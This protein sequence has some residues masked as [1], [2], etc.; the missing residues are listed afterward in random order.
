MDS[1]PSLGVYGFSGCGGCQAVLLDGD[2]LPLELAGRFEIR[3]YAPLGR[4]AAD[5]RVDVALVEGSVST[6]ADV[7]R[8][9]RIRSASAYL[10]ALGACAASGG[11]QSLRALARDGGRWAADVLPHPEWLDLLDTPV[12]LARHVRVD[13][14][15]Y[16]CPI[17][18]RALVKLLCDRLAGVAA[19]PER[20]PVCAECKEHGVPCLVVVRGE[21][22]L[23]PVTRAGCGALCPRGGR[24]CYACFGPAELSNVASLSARLAALGLNPDRIARC[25]HFVAGDVDAFRSAG[26]DG[27]VAGGPESP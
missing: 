24:P 13:A 10:V 25:F 1:K 2:G 12:P 18:R 27:L 7:E 3:N 11:P 4:L 8:L 14:V 23:G 22:C 6:P 19:R 15:L 21:P 17:D 26:G 5:A 9:K 20:R 16:G